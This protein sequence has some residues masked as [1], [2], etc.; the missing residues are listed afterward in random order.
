MLAKFRLA[1][2]G[3]PLHAPQGRANGRQSLADGGC[4]AKQRFARDKG[5]CCVF[6]GLI[7]SCVR[8]SWVTECSRDELHPE[9]CVQLTLSRSQMMQASPDKQV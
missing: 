4:L 6:K 7:G 1:S 3:L 8:A 5:P 2:A 9:K